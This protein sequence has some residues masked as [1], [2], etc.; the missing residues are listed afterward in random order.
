M[1]ELQPQESWITKDLQ[2]NATGDINK[3]EI[4]FLKILKL[5]LSSC[6]TL[7]VRV[8][9]HIIIIVYDL[10]F[11][12]KIDNMVCLQFAFILFDLNLRTN[13]CHHITDHYAITKYISIL[14]KNHDLIT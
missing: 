9:K 2:R 5:F 1:K 13:E 3:N 11:F 4:Q 6:N 7:E 8:N 10:K 14:I 12:D